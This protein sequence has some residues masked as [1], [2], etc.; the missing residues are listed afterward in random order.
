MPSPQSRRHPRPT[1][2]GLPRIAGRRPR[3]RDR[4]YWRD[5]ACRRSAP[6][7]A[8]RPHAEW[9]VRAP[10]C[11]LGVSPGEA[12]V[13]H[14]TG[15]VRCVRCAGAARRRTRPR[16]GMVRSWAAWQTSGGGTQRRKSPP[17]AATKK[18]R[19]WQGRKQGNQGRNQAWGGVIKGAA[20]RLRNLRLQPKAA[21]APSRGRGPG[22]AAPDGEGAPR[23]A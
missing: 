12:Q 5:R 9:H 22:T 1:C 18:P 20:M 14:V 23:N 16:S 3:W 7:K 13:F 11:A 8:I 6:R 2:R 19:H 21:P 10:I 17:M 4:R 15:L